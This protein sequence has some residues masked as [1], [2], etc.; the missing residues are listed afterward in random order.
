MRASVTEMTIP[1]G[2]D[3][4][5][6]LYKVDYEA[7][8]GDGYSCCSLWKTFGVY[9]KEHVAHFVCNQI[10]NGYIDPIRM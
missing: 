3:I 2:N 6:T 10:E 5:Q 8:V 1:I 9:E 7:A 4:A